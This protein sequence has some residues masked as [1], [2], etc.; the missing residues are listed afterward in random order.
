MK[1]PGCGG[2]MQ[3]GTVR[4]AAEASDARKPAMGVLGRMFSSDVPHSLFFLPGNEDDV[5]LLVRFDRGNAA[6][7]CPTC[8]LA[9]LLPQRP[10]P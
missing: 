7:H 9:V 6:Y 4:V 2:D 3:A 5:E 10:H 1:C 8:G